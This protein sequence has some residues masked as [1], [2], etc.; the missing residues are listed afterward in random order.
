MKSSRDVIADVITELKAANFVDGFEDT[1]DH[2]IRDALNENNPGDG[3]VFWNCVC[4]NPVRAL[5]ECFN[6]DQELFTEYVEFES[7][8]KKNGFQMPEWGTRGT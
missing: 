5:V 2:R 1:V 4:T 7:Y 6:G 3:K 8:A